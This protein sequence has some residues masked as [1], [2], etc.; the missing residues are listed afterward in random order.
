MGFF[1]RFR[2]QPEPASRVEGL[3]GYYELGEW[4]QTTF[5]QA[6]RDVIEAR[7]LPMGERSGSRPLTQGHVRSVSMPASEFLA[8]LAGWFRKVDDASIAQRIRAKIDE[9]SQT[10]PVSVP[11]YYRGR[12]YITFVEEVKALKCTG[13]NDAVERLL[14]ALVGAVEAE[15]RAKG[16]KWGVAP[17]YYDE[18]AVLYRKQKDY[19]AEVAILERFM[20]QPHAP[21]VKPPKLADRLENARMLLAKQRTSDS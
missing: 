6:E 3:L 18:L 4:W 9:L 14:L 2:K 12:H 13:D 21:G 16:P 19:A 7:Y 17:W 5:S 8:I 11:G 20:R 1:S 15:S 10:N